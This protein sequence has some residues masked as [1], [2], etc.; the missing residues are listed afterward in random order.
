VFLLTSNGYANLGFLYTIESII[1]Q[2]YSN[3]RLVV[4]DNKSNDLTA[5]T[6][7]HHL[8]RISPN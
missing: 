1:T 8:T 4:L 3:F 2:K 5:E 7:K 6:I